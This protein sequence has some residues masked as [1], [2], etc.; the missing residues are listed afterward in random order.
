MLGLVLFRG[1]KIASKKE[2]EKHTYQ[3]YMS[4]LLLLELLKRT[5]KTGP[6]RSLKRPVFSDKRPDRSFLT[7]GPG[8]AGPRGRNGGLIGTAGWAGL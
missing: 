1:E 4:T 6:D 5:E 8:R 2:G 3:R 7:G